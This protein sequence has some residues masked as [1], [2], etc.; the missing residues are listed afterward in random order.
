M[1][2]V[3][4]SWTTWMEKYGGTTPFQSYP[5]HDWTTMTPPYTTMQHQRSFTSL[6]YLESGFPCIHH[7]FLGDQPAGYQRCPNLLLVRPC[8]SSRLQASFR[9]RHSAAARPG[10]RHI[11]RIVETLASARIKTGPS[12][13][14]LSLPVPRDHPSRLTNHDNPCANT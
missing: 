8:C 5:N 1:S 12:S 4:L 9:W 3:G 7:A 6:L 2:W 11:P 13:S 14:S 10:I